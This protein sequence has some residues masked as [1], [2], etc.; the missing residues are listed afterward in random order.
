MKIALRNIKYVT[1]LSLT[2]F[3]LSQILILQCQYSINMIV[4]L[5]WCLLK[6]Q[7]ILS[8]WNVIVKSKILDNLLKIEFLLKDYFT[9]HANSVQFYYR[10]KIIRH[11]YW[12]KLNIHKTSIHNYFYF[13]KRQTPSKKVY[14]TKS[15]IQVYVFEKTW[16]SQK[17]KPKFFE[18]RHPKIV[19]IIEWSTKSFF[20]SKNYQC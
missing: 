13:I 10:T 2:L 6:C 9:V 8:W 19:T 17:C 12:E 18:N 3:S 14:T 20:R 16:L 1:K 5:I 11:L 4:G 15:L 7:S